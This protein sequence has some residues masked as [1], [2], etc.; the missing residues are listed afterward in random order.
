VQIYSLNIKANELPAS[1]LRL[2]HLR[3]GS[4]EIESLFEDAYGA[5]DRQAQAYGLSFR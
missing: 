4:E 2:G 1:L 5:I 3:E